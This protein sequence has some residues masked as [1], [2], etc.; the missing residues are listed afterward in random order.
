MDLSFESP[1]LLLPLPSST[2]QHISCSSWNAQNTVL[3]IITVQNINF[4]DSLPL[5]FTTSVA[6]S[7][8]E[9][10]ADLCFAG[11]KLSIVGLLWGLSAEERERESEFSYFFYFCPIFS[12][13][14]DSSFLNTPIHFLHLSN[15][16][17]IFHIHLF[18]Y[19]NQNS[20][21]CF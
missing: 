10:I 14:K 2:C 18:K 3:H 13:L 19:V 17:I 11:F 9:P 6:Y 7:G 20:A 12:S 1:D 21:P 15:N 5:S 4:I 16:L 8:V